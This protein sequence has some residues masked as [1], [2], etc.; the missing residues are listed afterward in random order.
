ME[1][2]GYTYIITNT[3]NSTIY[4]GSTTQLYTRIYEHRNKEN[5]NSFSARYN[6][7]KLV[8]FESFDNIQEAREREYY[9][10]GKRRKWKEELINSKNPDWNDLYNLIRNT[11]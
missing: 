8:Y 7:W 5:P 6:L 4:T 10:K 3:Y 1:R 2:G 9:I 11:D